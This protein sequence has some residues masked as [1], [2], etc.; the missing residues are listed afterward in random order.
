MSDSDAHFATS[1]GLRTADPEEPG[2]VRRRQGRGFSFRNPDGSVVRGEDRERCEALVLPPAWEDVW[3]CRHADGHL[4]AVG[5]DDAGRRQYRYHER[6]T[7]ARAAR[8]FDRLAS[9]GERLADVRRAVER[10]LESRD[11]TTRAMATMVGLLDRSLE[12][13]GNPTSV[14]VHGSRGI[15]TLSPANV[16]VSR[17]AIRLAFVGKGGVEHDV[18]II[19]ED[20][21]AAIADL[22]RKSSEWLFEVGGTVLDAAAANEYLDAHSGGELDCK[23]I[24]T[25]GGSA[26]A[27]AARATGSAR[28][29]PEVADAAA[30]ALHNTRTVARNSYVHPLVFEADDEV[31]EEAWKGSRRSKWYGRG[32]RALLNLLEGCPSLLEQYTVAR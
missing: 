4:Q 13:I 19:D 20:L 29:E 10:D 1:I 15:S 24:R 7:E 17:S 28:K 2:I 16:D 12:R 32:E 30:A 31:V 21:A 9:V 3:I 25:W 27:L 5:T 18:T 26:A 8:N 11:P 14:E 6:W 22:E 23:D